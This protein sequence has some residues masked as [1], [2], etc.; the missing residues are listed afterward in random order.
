MSDRRRK[1]NRKSRRKRRQHR[2]KTNKKKKNKSKNWRKRSHK[3]EKKLSSRIR[4]NSSRSKLPYLSGILVM[5]QL[6]GNLKSLCKI[7]EK[8]STLFYA[9]LES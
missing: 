7:L 3:R 1:K 8:S 4:N 6:R 5:T 2:R 9:K